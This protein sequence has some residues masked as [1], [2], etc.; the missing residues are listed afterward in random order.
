LVYIDFT[1]LNLPTLQL[2]TLDRCFSE[3][4]IWQVIRSLLLDKAP[5]P[6]SLSSL[7]YQI[8]W[9]VIKQDIMNAF[10][11]LWSKY[12]RGFY[13]LNQAHM[14]LLRK[15]RD[16]KMVH[17]F[18]PISLIHSFGK[19]VTKVLAM[20]LAPFMDNL[21][22]PNQSAFIKGRA[23]HDNFRTVHLTAKF[24]HA[25]PVSSALFKIDIAKTFDTVGGLSCWSCFAIYRLLRSL[26]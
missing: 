14:I 18:R 10:H 15:R 8:A 21:V 25:R 13:L 19:L 24:L 7:F 22:M 6:D 20:R 9:P 16:A 1:K 17:D 11:A 5:S 23:L 2:S 12:F 3:E 4:E 26:V